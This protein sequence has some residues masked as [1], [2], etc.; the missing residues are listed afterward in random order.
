MEPK[1]NRKFNGKQFVLVL[2]GEQT[3]V[4]LSLAV[5]DCSPNLP[6]FIIITCTIQCNWP[7]V[8]PNGWQIK[9]IRKL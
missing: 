7:T 4:G 1:F 3:H 9:T 5:I 6:A 2:H 8:Q